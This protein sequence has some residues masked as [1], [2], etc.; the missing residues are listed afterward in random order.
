MPRESIRALK[1]YAGGQP[2]CLDIGDVISIERGEK[3]VPDFEPDGPRGWI[4]QDE[5]RMP[6]YGLADLLHVSPLAGEFGSVLVVDRERPWGLAVDRVARLETGAATLQPLPAPAAGPGTSCFRGVIA[7]GDSLTLWLAP[8]FLRADAAPPAAA[9]RE[10]PGPATAVAAAPA[11]GP[12]RAK[13]RLLLFSP[14][15][16]IAGS[17]PGGQASRLLFGI[18]Y[19]QAIEIVSGVRYTPVPGAPHHVLGLVPWRSRS[20]TVVDVGALLGLA[21]AAA[22]ADGQIVIVR[23]PR[24]QSLIAIPV[25][26]GVHTRTLPLPHGPCPPGITLDPA[27]V[28][29][30]FSLDDERLLAMLDIDAMAA[31]ASG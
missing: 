9:K 25:G 19:S 6:V 1:C 12:A 15:N 2:Y 11:T 29:G 27:H 14:P 26:G 16:R 3:V 10:A 4:G 17:A 21:P 30:A 23:S 7:E 5:T 28:R 31:P 13:A 8:E 18:S 22:R 24:W 20:V